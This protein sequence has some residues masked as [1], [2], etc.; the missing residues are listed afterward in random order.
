MEVGV[1]EVVVPPEVRGLADTATL[2]RH[3]SLEPSV[4]RPV[5]VV[6]TQVPLPEH[7]GPVPVGGEDIGKR[8]LVLAKDGPS[9]AGCPR[10]VSD[11]PVSRHQR[12]AR[13]RAQR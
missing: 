5:R 6:V 8:D 7:P 1:V 9:P 4:L 12:A 13:R 2:V 3:H 10:T 11:R